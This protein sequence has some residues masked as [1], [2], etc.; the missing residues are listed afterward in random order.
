MKKSRF[1]IIPKSNNFRDIINVKEIANELKKKGHDC[2]TLT[3]KISDKNLEF[4]LEEEKF[5]YVFRVNNGK[6]EKVNKNIR[7]ISWISDISNIDECLHNYN[8]ND[9]IYTL[10]KILVIIKNSKLIKC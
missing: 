3:S 1:L 4:I 10:K 2:I 6:P 9:L 5:N 7:C 8:E